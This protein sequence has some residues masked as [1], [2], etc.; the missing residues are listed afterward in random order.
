M[1]AMQ[2]TDNDG[3]DTLVILNPVYSTTAFND[4]QVA[5]KA[6]MSTSI[7]YSNMIWLAVFTEWWPNEA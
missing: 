1:P 7:G 4:G 2:V 3:N 6:A 5:I